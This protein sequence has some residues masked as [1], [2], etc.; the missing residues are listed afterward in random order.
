M[1]ETGHFTMPFLLIDDAASS[2]SDP[3]YHP[4]QDIMVIMAYHMP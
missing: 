2:T 1:V 4:V 3:E